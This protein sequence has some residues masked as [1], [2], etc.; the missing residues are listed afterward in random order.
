MVCPRCGGFASVQ[1]VAQRKKRGCLMAILWIYLA[2]ITFGAIIWIPLLI[3]KG[4]KV[5]SWAVC[6]NCG[7]R[8]KVKRI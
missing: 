3:R 5:F 4:D 1:A 2:I 6:Q 7:Y 8:W